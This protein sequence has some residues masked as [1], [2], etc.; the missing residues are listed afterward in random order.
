MDG[1][2]CAAVHEEEDDDGVKGWFMG[3]Y[4]S[5]PFRT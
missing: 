5:R 3:G 2:L 1:D 4:V